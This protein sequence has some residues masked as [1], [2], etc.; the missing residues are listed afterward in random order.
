MRLVSVVVPDWL[1]ATTSTVDMSSGN[2][3]PER[4]Q[5]ESS[6]PGIALTGMWGNAAAMAVATA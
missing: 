5:P 4:P 6:L 3:A 1:M 2:P